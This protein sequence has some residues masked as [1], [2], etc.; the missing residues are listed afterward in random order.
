M[1][2]VPKFSNLHYPTCIKASGVTDLYDNWPSQSHNNPK[3]TT[4]MNSLLLFLISLINLSFISALPQ[5]R[6]K[7]TSTNTQTVFSSGTWSVVYITTT[8]TLT[9]AQG[10]FTTTIYESPVTVT[11]KRPKSIVTSLS[12]TTVLITTNKVPAITTVT[13]TNDA[14]TASYIETVT[15]YTASAITTVLLETSDSSRNFKLWT[16]L[17]MTLLLFGS[18]I[19]FI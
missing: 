3:N 16:G 19:F 1:E 13:V 15:R 9:Q 8:T 18:F 5:H 17:Q 14:A 7:C 4:F 2:F 11:V 10:T 6:S 12:T